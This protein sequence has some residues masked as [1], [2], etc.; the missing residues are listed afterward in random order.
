M[1]LYTPDSIEILLALG[2]ILAFC[3]LIFRFR[4]LQLGG[5]PKGVAVVLFLL[6]CSIAFGFVAVFGIRSMAA[7]PTLFFITASISIKHG[8]K[9]QTIF[10]AYY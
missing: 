10:S 4:K 1:P 3:G 8:T 6:K 2:L 5:L 7:M 9:I